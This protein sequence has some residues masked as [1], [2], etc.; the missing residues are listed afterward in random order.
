MGSWR[1]PGAKTMRRRLLLAVLVCACVP[2]EQGHAQGAAATAVS[3]LLQQGLQDLRL[4]HNE[5]ALA[6]FQQALSAEPDNVSAN[7]LA[8]SAAVQLIQPELAVHYAEL[9]RTLDP[10]DWRVGTTLVA[11]YAIAGRLHDRDEERR[12]LRAL[13]ASG[14]ERDAR[15]TSGFLLDRFRVGSSTVDAV[16]YFTPV[17]AEH[18]FFRFIVHGAGWGISVESEPRNEASWAA[19]HPEEAASGKQ[20]FQMVGYDAHSHLE[21]TSFTGTA[22]YDLIKARAIAWITAHPGGI[23]TAR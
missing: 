21:Q 18:I 9:A 15:E 19:A 2:R 5:Q 6:L 11:A 17:T 16:E 4:E 8:A 7:L 3:P 22:D 23:G 20:Q 1:G 12:K 13:H 14:A 10:G